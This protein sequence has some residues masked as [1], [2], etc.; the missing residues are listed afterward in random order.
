[1]LNELTVGSNMLLVALERYAAACLAI[2]ELYARGEKPHTINPQF[3]PRLDTQIDL[4]TSLQSKLARAKAA[5]SW[6]RNY[7]H[8]HVT[9]NDLPPEVLARVFH[10]VLS[11]QPCTKR[12]YHGVDKTMDLMYP[13]VLSRVC[14]RWHRIVF[15][16]PTLWTHIDLSTSTLLNQ[17]C[18]D[19]LTKLHL[20]Q[21]GTL[22]LG[23]HV[24]DARGYEISQLSHGGGIDSRITRSITRLASRTSS[25]NM[26]GLGAATPNG[27]RKVMSAL[28][29][30][31]TPGTLTNLTISSGHSNHFYRG[32]G[33][34]KAK[35][36]PVDYGSIMDLPKEQLENILEHVSVLRLAGPYLRWTSRAY[37]GLVELRLVGW[38][39]IN[40]SDLVG[41]LHS[42]PGLRIFQ[43]GLRID[44]L[45]S[46]DTQV[47]P[48]LLRDLEV[49]IV[50]Q[51]GCTLLPSLLRWIAPGPKPLQF[52]FRAQEETYMPNP[53]VLQLKEDSLVSF[54][55]RSRLSKV[56][57]RYASIISAIDLLGLSTGIQ[58][59][60]ISHT[61]F[62]T[63]P[64]PEDATVGSTL[65]CHLRYFQ[66]S[67]SSVHMEAVL[68]FVSYPAFTIGT[69]VFHNCGLLH[70]G[71][72][73]P[74]D[75]VTRQVEELNAS[76]PE[77]RFIIRSREEP[78]LVHVESWDAGVV[79]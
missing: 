30:D 64:P 72:H 56:D 58:E 1:M 42:S 45:L 52:A 19:G 38:E 22:L 39:T 41:I 25:F 14:S 13:A 11:G 77:V 73:I 43:L 15:S 8:T 55:L 54:F 5:I 6:S 49:L 35:D 23:V 27:Y 76:C 32:T 31:S 65:K 20:S 66:V 29:Q 18:L 59:L 46:I 69:V 75:Q 10:L 40:E 48:V 44:N 47:T 28:F 16:T 53:K 7:A 63:F 51:V 26:D 61:S 21:V 62:D 70:R 17:Q 2:Q 9:V 71:V 67:H 74:D 24:F 78:Y 60:A 4:A 3:L 57:G 36:D 50:W 37:H 33:F 79:L 12:D 34:L 68:A